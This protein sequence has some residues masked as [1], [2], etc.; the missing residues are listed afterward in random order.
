MLPPAHRLATVCLAIAIVLLSGCVG[1]G[2]YLEALL[3]QEAAR[4][5]AAAAKTDYADAAARFQTL[6][7]ELAALQAEYDAQQRAAYQQQSGDLSE[8]QAL[9]NERTLQGLVIDSLR[10][11][12]ERLGAQRV[13]ALAVVDRRDERLRQ[14]RERVASRTGNFLPGQFTLTTRDGAVVLEI[15]ERALFDDRRP[16]G[17]SAFGEASLGNIAGAL[18][19]Q[20]DL[21]IDVIAAPRDRSGRPEA[22]VEAARR[23]ALVVSYLVEGR[24][25]L[26]EIVR[27][28]ATQTDAGT[29][30]VAGL[31]E[32]GG[33]PT[34]RIEVSVP[35]DG[36]G[37]V[38]RALR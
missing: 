35:G 10:R 8:R 15:D 37:Q 16:P 36:L 19:G 28:V 6:Q 29:A 33:L 9:L 20:P 11:V 4:S 1:R 18:G 31:V 12:T 17:V 30:S 22:R 23:A 3:A 26:P 32:D 13:N 5:E 21:R 27:A 25:L 24:G 7:R 34:M 38:G 14:I 2:K